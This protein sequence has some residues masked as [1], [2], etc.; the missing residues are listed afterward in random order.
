MKNGPVLKR[1]ITLCKKARLITRTSHQIVFTKLP[2]A[3]NCWVSF[4]FTRVANPSF[5]EQF[6]NNL[7]VTHLRIGRIVSTSHPG[8]FYTLHFY[9]N[10]TYYCLQQAAQAQLGHIF[11][12]TVCL[13]SDNTQCNSFNKK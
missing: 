6:F 11:R 13:W 5:Q 7:N 8:H 12:P 1:V 10:F 4:A 9:W 3:F 2:S